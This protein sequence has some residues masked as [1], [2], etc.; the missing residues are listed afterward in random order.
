MITTFNNNN[1]QSLPF[2]HNHHHLTNREA[3]ENQSL[4][5]SYQVQEGGE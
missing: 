4:L 5:H 3:D 1:Q 2:L